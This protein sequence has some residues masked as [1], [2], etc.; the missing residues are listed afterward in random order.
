MGLATEGVVVQPH[1][2]NGAFVLADL[3]PEDVDLELYPRH[4]VLNGETHLL[5]LLGALQ[6]LPYVHRKLK[7]DGLMAIP[8]SSEELSNSDVTFGISG[9]D[10]VHGPIFFDTSLCPVRNTFIHFHDILEVSE[11]TRRT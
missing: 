11:R 4:V 9:E 5:A 3:A 1:W 10:F 8:A 6:H 7:P 2:A